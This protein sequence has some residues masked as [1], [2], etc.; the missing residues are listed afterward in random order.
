[1]H[2]AFVASRD[3]GLKEFFR[4]YHPP[5]RSRRHTCVGLGMEV[6]KLLRGLDTDFPGIAASAMLVSCDESVQDAEEYARAGAGPQ[7]FLLDTE[8][9]HVMVACHLRVAGRPGV[10]LSDLGYHIARVVTVMED[11]TYPHTDWFT[12]SDQQ[13]CRKEYRYLLCRHNLNYVEWHVRETRAGRSDDRL[14]LVYVAQEYLSAV[15]VTEKRNLAWIKKSLVARNSEGH[16]KAG[17]NLVCKLR[18]MQLTVF[19]DGHQ[20][21]EKKKFKF[22]ELKEMQNVSDELAGALAQCG[23]QLRLRDG[24]LLAL[25]GRLATVVADREFLAELLE[26]NERIVQLA[27]GKHYRRR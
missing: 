21:R 15:E 25:V 1:M 10:L 14:A 2:K 8:K 11:C 12:H 20:G 18:D 3:N 9:D 4:K 7:G 22:E 23:E 16:A 24:E 27:A 19:Y 13:N 26:I 6:L 5:I 17:V